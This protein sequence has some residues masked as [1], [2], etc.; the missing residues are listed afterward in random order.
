MPRCPA[1]FIPMT[2][3]EEESM[4]WCV[5]SQCLGAWIG[6]VQFVRRLRMDVAQCTSAEG[7][8]GD[9]SWATTPLE[10]L[11]AQ[12]QQENRKK[13]LRCPQCEHEM[14]KDRYH[15]MIPITIDRCKACNSL[16]LDRGEMAMLRRLYVEMMTSTD[17]QI[18]RL[19]E[20][21]AMTDLQMQTRKAEASTIG[22]VPTTIE[23]YAL[24][25]LVRILGA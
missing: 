6:V 11:A 16:W 9:T 14:R 17:P 8:Q 23:G 22:T 20:K 5:C 10:E 3:V 25:T 4:H 1:C 7:A 12:V 18:L 15:P 21:I 2:R 24:S 19:K 13:P